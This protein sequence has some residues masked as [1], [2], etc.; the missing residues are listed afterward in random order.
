[1]LSLLNLG[2]APLKEEIV[3]NCQQ[4]WAEEQGDKAK[5]R[6]AA[7]EAEKAEYHGQF[8]GPAKGIRPEKVIDTAD[9]EQSPCR[10]ENAPPNASRGQQ[11]QRY[12]AP[13]QRSR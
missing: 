13:R 7:D 10:D 9:E 6:N 12:Q 3:A 4:R 2:G 8:A 1:M 11:P 5:G